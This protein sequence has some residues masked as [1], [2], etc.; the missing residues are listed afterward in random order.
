MKGNK[1]FAVRDYMIHNNVKKFSCLL[2]DM[3]KHS[4]SLL[5]IQSSF[6]IIPNLK[7]TLLDIGP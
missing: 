6:I 5:L 3:G 7:C 1:S 4:I 2:K